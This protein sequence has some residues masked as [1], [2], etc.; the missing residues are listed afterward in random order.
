MKQDYIK[1]KI[2]HH[3]DIKNNCWTAIIVSLSGTFK[4]L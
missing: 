3:K 1:E 4:F 2:N